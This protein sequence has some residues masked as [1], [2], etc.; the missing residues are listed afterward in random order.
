MVS[1]PAVVEGVGVALHP[2][3]GP[4]EGGV[5]SHASILVQGKPRITMNKIKNRIC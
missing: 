5:P 2:A 1:L 4:L 3:L